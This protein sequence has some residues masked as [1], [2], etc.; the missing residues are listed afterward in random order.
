MTARDLFVTYHPMAARECSQGHT[1][2]YDA[3]KEKSW[4][5]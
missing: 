3:T 2:T 4:T 1:K 5:S